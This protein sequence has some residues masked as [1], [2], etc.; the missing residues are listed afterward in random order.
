MPDKESI[1][2]DRF[3]GIPATGQDA[4]EGSAGYAENTDPNLAEGRMG[5][6]PQDATTTFSPFTSSALYGDDEAITYSPDTGLFTHLDFASASETPIGSP[7]GSSMNVPGMASDGRAVHVGCG[8]ANIPAWVG[9]IGGTFTVEEGYLRNYAP[10]ISGSTSIVPLAATEG[11]Y[12]QNGSYFWAVAFGYDNGTQTSPLVQVLM[13]DGERLAYHVQGEDDDFGFEYVNVT[14][15]LPGDISPRISFVYLFRSENPRSDSDPFSDWTLVETTE[16][17]GQTQI[18]YQ[19]KGKGG[20]SFEDHAGFSSE[21]EHMR[22]RYGQSVEIDGV[23][24]VMDVDFDGNDQ[25][26]ETTLFFSKPYRFDTFDWSEDF[27]DLRTKPVALENWAGRLWAFCSGS[28]FVVSP[29]TLVEEDRLEGIGAFGPQSV[30][31]TDR[32]MFWADKRNVYWHNGNQVVPIG[33]GLKRLRYK[34][35][36][37]WERVLDVFPVVVTYNAEYDMVVIFTS[38]GEALAEGDRGLAL[39]TI[40]GFSVRDRDWRIITAPGGNNLSGY[41]ADAAIMTAS[42]RSVISTSGAGVAAL[43]EDEGFRTPR[44]ESPWLHARGE[45]Y[46]YYYLRFEM[47]GTGIGE[48]YEDGTDVQSAW[49]PAQDRNVLENTQFPVYRFT[50]NSNPTPPWTKVRG[51]RIALEAVDPET[52]FSFLQLVRRQ[53]GVR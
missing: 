7:P 10:D 52:R 3:Y 34:P 45:V 49:L 48:Y 1:A 35:E 23:H 21:L 4:R 14:I 44:W 13:T 8:P 19:D 9:K 18:V 24:V 30:V 2:I 22:V 33:E 11:G 37:A 17:T 5:G 16:Y 41:Q 27:L 26:R 29:G 38:T 47:T 53:I 36:V 46:T 25:S 40:Y 15:N 42:G 12:F 51:F 28:T 43:F 20:I 50:V 31:V 6:L 39:T 32:G